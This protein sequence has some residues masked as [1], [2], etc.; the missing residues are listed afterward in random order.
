MRAKARNAAVALERLL[1]ERFSEPEA[2]GAAGG[3]GDWV[4]FP[5]NFLED[6]VINMDEPLYIL[7]FIYIYVFFI[8]LGMTLWF[9]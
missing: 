4:K 2:L 8:I 6:P 3:C 1:E 7:Y 5:W 9:F